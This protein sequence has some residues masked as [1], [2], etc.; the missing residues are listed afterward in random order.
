MTQRGITTENA[1]PL[2][3]HTQDVPRGTDD[4]PASLYLKVKPGG[5]GKVAR[6]PYF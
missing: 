3:H 1:G 5:Q 2:L 4:K 6:C